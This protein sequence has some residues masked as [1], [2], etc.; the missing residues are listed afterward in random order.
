MSGGVER[1][2]RH[3]PHVKILVFKQ[4]EELSDVVSEHGVDCLGLLLDGVLDSCHHR[5]PHVGVGRR[6]V[7]K[8]LG[9]TCFVVYQHQLPQAGGD[10]LPRTFLRGLH[11][12]DEEVPHAGDVRLRGKEL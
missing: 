3:P 9:E 11:V 7:S 1:D 8:E 6:D 5:A 2:K 4:G 12:L 10:Y